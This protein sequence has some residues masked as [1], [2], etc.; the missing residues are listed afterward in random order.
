[1]RGSG[2]LRDGEQHLGCHDRYDLRRPQP[3]SELSAI[4]ECGAEGTGSGVQR[5]YDFI[6]RVSGYSCNNAASVVM[7][8]VL[9][10]G[11]YF[12]VQWQE[13]GADNSTLMFFSS[14]V[15]EKYEYNGQEAGMA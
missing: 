15:S 8:E 2:R 6:G 4:E 5:D 13:L 7:R 3:L 1:M 11:T 9:R 10:S 14:M 12:V